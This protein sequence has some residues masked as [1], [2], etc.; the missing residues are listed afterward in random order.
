MKDSTI[1]IAVAAKE[2]AQKESLIAQLSMI[3]FEAF[4]ELPDCVNAFIPAD[5]F[6]EQE[7]VSVLG[8]IS[9][10]KTEIDDEILGL[11]VERLQDGNKRQTSTPRPHVVL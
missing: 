4:E 5:H 1:Q 9:Y 11:E 7:L 8:D 6:D 10:E 3:G 2:E